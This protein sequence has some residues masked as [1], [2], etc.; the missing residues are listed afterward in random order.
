MPKIVSDLKVHLQVRWTNRNHYYLM[1][2]I[3][4]FCCLKIEMWKFF[5]CQDEQGARQET[6]QKDF[7]YFFSDL[8]HNNISYR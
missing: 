5:N 4:C 7:T 8:Q 6:K 3:N 2:S 1:Q